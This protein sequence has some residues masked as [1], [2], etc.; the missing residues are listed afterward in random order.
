MVPRRS[1]DLGNS[2]VVGETEDDIVR[3]SPA[4][5]NGGIAQNTIRSGML[6]AVVGSHLIYA[7][8][9]HWGTRHHSGTQYL[10][11]PSEEERKRFLGNLQAALKKLENA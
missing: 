1:G 4:A 10:F 8:A 11:N 9:Q 6:G 2:I 3:N 5:A 7:R